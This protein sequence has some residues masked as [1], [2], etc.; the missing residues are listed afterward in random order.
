MK[1]AMR[2]EHGREVTNGSGN[3]QGQV[4]RLTYEEVHTHTC[5]CTTNKS[6]NNNSENNTQPHTGPHTFTRSSF[7]TAWRAEPSSPSPSSSSS[8]SSLLCTQS[9]LCRH[10]VDRQ[11]V[12][13]ASESSVLFNCPK[14]RFAIPV[15]P[16]HRQ[17][18]ELTRN[19]TN[20]TNKA[21][22]LC[23]MI[24]VELMVATMTKPNTTVTT[25]STALVMVRR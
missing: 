17:T 6:N 2:K 24:R 11:T 21:S 3:D 20:D 7:T 22:K 9:L 23:M 25:T 8:S 12:L 1:H 15:T 16:P 14:I 5:T 19:T 18:T 4:D 13:R 10:V